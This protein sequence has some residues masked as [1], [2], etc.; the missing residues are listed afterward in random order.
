M[1]I[2]LVTSALGTTL[3]V[4]LFP[5]L[6]LNEADE[7]TEHR[8][9]RYHLS[10]HSLRYEFPGPGR[11][12]PGHCHRFHCLPGTYQVTEHDFAERNRDLAA[13][14]PVAA[15]VAACNTEA[16]NDRCVYEIPLIHKHAPLDSLDP[17]PPKKRGTLVPQKRP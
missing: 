13:R 14:L 10:R 2:P 15:P 17:A 12:V 8:S 3:L 7:A 9:L 1:R 11:G 4:T 5:E 16:R 6:S